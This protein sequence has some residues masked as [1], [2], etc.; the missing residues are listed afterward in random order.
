MRDDFIIRKLSA[1]RSVER[2]S[3]T[4]V[5]RVAKVQVFAA[6]LSPL[7]CGA[8]NQEASNSQE[9]N[10]SGDA[11]AS[12]GHQHLTGPPPLDFRTY[13]FRSI[14]NGVLLQRQRECTPEVT[15]H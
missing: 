2:S 10:N 12:H 13:Y 15:H 9:R 3:E 14:K 6:L 1:C 11:V 8:E 4:V 7:P 5:E